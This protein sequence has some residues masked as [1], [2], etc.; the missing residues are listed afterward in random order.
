MTGL[1]GL[2]RCS[3]AERGSV[4][5]EA[6]VALSALVLVLTFCLAALAA[7]VAQVRIVDAAGVAA[8]LA[9]RGDPDAARAAALRLAPAG[10]DLSISESGELLTVRVTGPAAGSLLPGVHLAAQ[11]VIAREPAMQAP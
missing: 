3:I 2:R 1:V 9:A 11:V 10:S 8:R 6:A 4:T 7:M 5:V